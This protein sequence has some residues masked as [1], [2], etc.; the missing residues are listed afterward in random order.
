[1]VEE[2]DPEVIV[3]QVG[4]WERLRLLGDFAA[5]QFLE[6]GTYRPELVDPTL[7]LLEDSGAHVV[8][9]SP[10]PIEDAEESEFVQELGAD[11]L[12]S[13]EATTDAEWL[14]V[15]PAIAPD[16]FAGELDGIRV[17]RSDGIH[18]CPA[19]QVL[20]AGVV[21]DRLQELDPTLAPAEGWDDPDE[22]CGP[23]DPAVT[24]E[25]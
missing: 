7:A 4:H 3:V 19:G 1:V 17:R 15:R 9:L 6:P 24:G 14:D 5:G 12:A 23:Y 16:G 10:I 20:V 13:V 25:N 21:L 11:F 8:W 18:L 2:A 22:T